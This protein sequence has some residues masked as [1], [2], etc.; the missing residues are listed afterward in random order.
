MISD[1][2]TKESM[3]TNMP[4]TANLLENASNDEIKK[5][6]KRDSRHTIPED[7]NVTDWMPEIPFWNVRKR[8]FDI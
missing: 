8:F 3:R 7:E 6:Q 1:Q 4:V 2:A 5:Y